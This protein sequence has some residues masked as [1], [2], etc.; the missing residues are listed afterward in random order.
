V[1]RKIA[2]EANVSTIAFSHDGALLRGLC[3]DNKLRAWD[4]AAGAIRQTITFDDG[5][6]A[7]N[8]SAAGLTTLGKD[9]S[10]KSWDLAT[11][12]VANRV[13]SAGRHSRRATGSADGSVFLSTGGTEIKLR[14]LDAAGK[15]RFAVPSGLG[16][17]G[18]LALSPDGLS[19]VAASYD[20]DVR[21]WNSRN[22]ELLRL[23]DELPVSMF[24]LKFSPDGKVL[25]AAGADRIVYLYDAKTWK[26][27]SQLKG[28][29]EMIS[30]LAFS[31]D[32]TRLASGGF[33]ELTQ[34]RPVKVIVWDVKSGQKVRIFD[35]NQRVSCIVFSPDGKWTAVSTASKSVDLWQVAE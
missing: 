2:S 6:T 29:P 26:I 28:Q 22:G 3:A 1:D 18:A 34:K 27:A 21:A 5:D 24:D 7:P 9:G 16:G 20:A 32:G 10:L 33:S 23:I 13:P 15:E 14:A 11:G 12:K 19:L 17:L 4:V 35:A 30:A 25:A 8:F 31:P